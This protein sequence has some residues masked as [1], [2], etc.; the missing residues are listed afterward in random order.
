MK[1]FKIMKEPVITALETTNL[2]DVARLLLDNNIGC[3]PVVD[4]QGEICGIITESD[5]AAK[6]KTVPFSTFRALQVLGQWLTKENVEQIYQMAKVTPAEKIMNHS[7]IT[8]TEDDSVEKAV[9]LM[10]AHDITRI[11]IVRNKKPVGIIAKHDLLW[12]LITE[13][14]KKVDD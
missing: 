2:A 6:E 11:P 5:F 1:L 8:L 4:T 12:L 14:E 3:V 9:E 7:V 13:C 10:L